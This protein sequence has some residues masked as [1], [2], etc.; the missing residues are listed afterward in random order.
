MTDSHTS[1]RTEHPCCHLSSETLTLT[2]CKNA[3]HSHRYRSYEQ[4]TGGKHVDA[5]SESV[6]VLFQQDFKTQIVVDLRQ[7][8]AY[9]C[10]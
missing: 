10:N 2:F 4:Y 8:T 3:A 7:V 1:V 9:A 6:A 5:H